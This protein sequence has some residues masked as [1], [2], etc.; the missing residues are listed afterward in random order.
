[1]KKIHETFRH[2]R[3]RS[4]HFQHGLMTVFSAVMILVLMG[5]VIGKIRSIEK[6]ETRRA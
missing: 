6:P 1:M 3:N 5:L 4:L 2:Q